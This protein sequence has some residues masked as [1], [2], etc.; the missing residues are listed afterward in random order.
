MEKDKSLGV[1]GWLWPAVRGGHHLY[2]RHHDALS[3]NKASGLGGGGEKH[4]PGPSS[5]TYE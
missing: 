2:H 4:L 5:G 3:W 1:R